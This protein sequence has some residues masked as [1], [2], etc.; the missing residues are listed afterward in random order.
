VEPT[1]LIRVHPERVISWGIH[2]D[3]VGGRHARRVDM[4]T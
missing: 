4:S 2:S 1:P 3:V